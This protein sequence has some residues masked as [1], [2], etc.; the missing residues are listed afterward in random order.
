MPPTP[1]TLPVSVISPVIATSATTGWSSAS[2][3]SELTM[4]TPADGPSFGVA[5]SG[6]WRWIEAVSKNLLPAPTAHDAPPRAK[7]T[8]CATRHAQPTA[9]NT[10]PTTDDGTLAAARTRR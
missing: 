7:A 1:R 5:P 10:Q 4:V 2:E 3:S 8:S 6:T 9:D